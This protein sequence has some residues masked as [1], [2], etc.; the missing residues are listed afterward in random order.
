MKELNAKDIL[1]ILENNDG[2]DNYIITTHINPDGDAI[3]SALGIYELL[4]KMNEKARIINIS[5]TPD[6]LIFLDENKIIEQFELEKHAELFDEKT[7]TIIL[8]LNDPKRLG[9]IGKLCLSC[10]EIIVID[11][12]LFPKPFAHHYYMDVESASTAEM[13][14]KIWQESAHSLSEIAAKAIYVGIMTD[15]GSFRFDR[16]SADTFRICANLLDNGADPEYL[17]N[18]IHGRNSHA[19]LRLLGSSLNSIEL[20]HGGRL[21]LMLLPHKIFEETGTSQKDTEGFASQGLKIAGVNLAITITE[22]KSPDEL[23]ISFRS[24]DGIS[25]RELAEEFGGGGH[26]YASGARVKN[27]DFNKIKEV[28]IKSAKALF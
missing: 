28:V 27:G 3:G 23:R 8:D 15:T 21:S 5:S 17:Y 20:H 11:H 12:H 26:S 16:T 14:W 1:N 2:V 25:T 6:E 9:E 19:G 18:M 22:L 4:Q 24:R 10:G 7:C 13:V